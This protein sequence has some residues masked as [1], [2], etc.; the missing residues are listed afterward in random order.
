MELLIDRLEA[1]TKLSQNRSADDRDGVIDGLEADG[2]RGVS[3]AM[4]DA[5][6]PVIRRT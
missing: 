4:R 3:A 2:E 5:A 6:R 1:K